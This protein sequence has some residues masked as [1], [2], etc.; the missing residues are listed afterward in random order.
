[1]G[2]YASYTDNDGALH[3]QLEVAEQLCKIYFDIAC[4]ALGENKVKELR[5]KEIS[6]IIEQKRRKE[7]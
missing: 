4:I 7:Q 3:K 5:D 2:I 1:M 6:K